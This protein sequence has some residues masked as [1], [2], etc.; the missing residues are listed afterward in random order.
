MEWNPKHHRNEGAKCISD[1]FLLE[2]DYNTYL[3][4][5]KDLILQGYKSEF[6]VFENTIKKYY[7][8]KK[9]MKEGE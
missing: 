7:Q 2:I 6:L 5:S 4:L 3:K 1:C 9:A 8:E